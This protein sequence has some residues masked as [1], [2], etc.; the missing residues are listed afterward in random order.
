MV[1]FSKQK[2]T[3]MFDD[4]DIETIALRTTGLTIETQMFVHNHYLM[5]PTYS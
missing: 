3:Q 4:D 5:L 2:K 1:H